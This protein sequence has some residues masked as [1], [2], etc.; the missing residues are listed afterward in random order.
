MEGERKMDSR[1]YSGLGKAG[2]SFA[3]K[4]GYAVKLASGGID[5]CAAATDTPI[6][7]IDSVIVESN[8]LGIALPG[9]VVPVKVSGTVA[10]FSRGV[11]DAGG[12]AKQETGTE[13]EVVFC[14]FLNDGVADETVNALIFNPVTLA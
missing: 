9:A 11:L 7:V 3:D 12:K 8:R 1:I 4:S 10:A 2:V 14:Q 13:G 6:G 5:L